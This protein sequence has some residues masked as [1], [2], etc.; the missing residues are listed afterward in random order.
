M[1]ALGGAARMLCAGYLDRPLKW[2]PDGLFLI[3]T[4]ASSASDLQSLY[5]VDAENGERL[6]LTTPP[7]AR[8]SDSAPAFAPGGRVLAFLRNT[9][10]N[11]GLYLLDLSKDFRPVIE[12]KLLNKLD[13]DI[14]ED[15]S[16]TSDGKDLIY[17]LHEDH[18]VRR[19][20]RI[21]ATSGA[22]PR[23]LTPVGRVITSQPFRFVETGWRTQRFCRTRTFCK[24]GRVVRHGALPHQ[25]ATRIR[26][27]TLLTVITLS[28]Q[29]E[30]LR[31]FANLDVRQR[32]EEPRAANG[33]RPRNRR[34]APLVPGR[35]LD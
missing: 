30:S 9:G 23:P 18:A 2:S 4:Y 8:I 34:F 22:Q 13:V 32:R 17:S 28:F 15:T 20:M 21:H 33:R 35:T 29:L 25:R 7:N 27:N 10:W 19:L 16:W 3:V 6:R 24:Y 31:P 12:P 5:L 14:G 11:C 1:P 26:H